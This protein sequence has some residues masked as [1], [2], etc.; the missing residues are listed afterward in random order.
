M[1]PGLRFI[2]SQRFVG[3]FS[4]FGAALLVAIFAQT[5]LR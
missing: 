1:N 5:V 4:L 2:T 3:F